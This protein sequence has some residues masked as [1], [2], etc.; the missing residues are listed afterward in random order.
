[1]D[2]KAVSLIDYSRRL[3]RT[4]ILME[5][6]SEIIWKSGDRK[7]CRVCVSGSRVHVRNTTYRADGV[8]EKID[9][10]KF[11]SYSD[12]L[13]FMNNNTREW[14]GTGGVLLFVYSVILTRGIKNIL[15]DA[16]CMEDGKWVQLLTD[17][18]EITCTLINLLLTGKA[19]V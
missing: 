15:K 19:A 4:K 6:L 8:T 2:G 12:L 5:C 11:E 7:S 18:E 13:T 14:R 16:G 3:N 1:M 17:W 9:I 10:H